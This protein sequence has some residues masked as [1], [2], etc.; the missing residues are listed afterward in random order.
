MLG[1]FRERKADAIFTKKTDVVI[2][3]LIHAIESTTPKAK[4]PVT[5][6]THLFIVLKRFI[7][8]KMLDRCLVY[9][10]RKELGPIKSL[11]EV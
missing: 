1:D 2:K 9:L 4:Y 3:K 5:F 7:S 10:S 8:T 11:P 6:P